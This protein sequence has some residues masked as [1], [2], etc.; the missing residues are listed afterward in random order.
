MKKKK[1][2]NQWEHSKKRLANILRNNLWEKSA[3]NGQRS[4][5]LTS[6]GKAGYSLH[7]ALEKNKNKNTPNIFSAKKIVMHTV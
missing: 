1:K 4:L 5:S 7:F 2:K 6:V 3:H